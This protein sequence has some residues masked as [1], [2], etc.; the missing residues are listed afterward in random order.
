MGAKANF[1]GVSNIATARVANLARD[2]ALLRPFVDF[3]I[4]EAEMRGCSAL[5][6]YALGSR[7]LADHRVAIAASPRP[8]DA[9]P[10][11]AAIATS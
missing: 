6:T 7:P 11:G 10:T 8:M 3:D 2:A 1:F 5:A 4:V 9:T